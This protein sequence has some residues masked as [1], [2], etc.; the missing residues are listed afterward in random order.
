MNNIK[1]LTK[2]SLKGKWNKI[3]IITFILISVYLITVVFDSL[4]FAIFKMNFI[5]NLFA[6][7]LNLLLIIVLI[8]PLIYGVYYWFYYTLNG[9]NMKI[10]SCFHFF[11]NFSNYKKAVKLS[12]LITLKVSLISFV[13]SLPEIFALFFIKNSSIVFM[14]SLITF[15]GYIFSILQALKYFLAPILLVN[16]TNLIAN[17]A[18]YL[19]KQI[20][21]GKK[22]NVFIF[23]LSFFGYFASC[24]LVIPL[25]YV[26]PFYIA[27]YCK[28]CKSLIQ[29]YNVMIADFNVDYYKQ[30]YNVSK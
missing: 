8:N 9:N 17:E 27:C 30:L 23:I 2:E 4:I 3:I 26:I 21:F 29:E 28:K 6:K 15:L 19:S 12:F 16:N 11:V 20:I 25:F 5:V 13:F 18:L 24:I 22:K 1:I 10:N 7:L 14:F